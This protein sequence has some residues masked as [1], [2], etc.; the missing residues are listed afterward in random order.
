MATES[1]LTPPSTENEAR[2]ERQAREGLDLALRRLSEHGAVG[3]LALEARFLAE[4]EGRH[5]HA[6]W[7]RATETLVDLTRQSL[8]G[9]LLPCDMVL[10][11][12]VRMDELLVLFFRPRTS[13]RFFVD[14]LPTLP[15]A[16]SRFLLAHRSRIGHGP[17]GTLSS[18]PVGHA[19]VL[20]N[21]SAQLRR[22]FEIGVSR[23]RADGEL[24]QRLTE[25]SRRHELTRMI[26]GRDM[27]IVY[28]PILELG[29]RRVLGYE[30][31]LRVPADGVWLSPDDVFRTAEREGMIFELDVACRMAGL[32]GVRNRLRHDERLFLNTVPSAIHDPRFQ[33][34]Q[35][36]HLLASC[37]LEPRQI[38]VEL[39]ERSCQQNLRAVREARERLRA[40]G[41]SVALDD[42][43]NSP[44]SIST[45]M[46][47][48]PEFVKIDIALVRSS[49]TDEARQ[50]LVRAVQ[51]TVEAIGAT[52]IAEGIETEAELEALRR[53]GVQWGQGFLL[54]RP[55]RIPAGQG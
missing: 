48:D 52:S 49:D 50:R 36:G 35:F 2:R 26:L 53:L 40:L 1:V 20:H 9:H 18:L 30:A 17:G 8:E 13:L 5:G 51:D 4:I 32:R 41:I 7:R 45:L 25:K 29:E 55:A 10:A 28:Q 27:E 54:G 19:L 31:L 21:P 33:R 37:G 16:L 44:A 24:F 47:L 14:V 42:I 39:S 23:A 6:A 11:G 15:N 12:D 22:E 3:I 46:D 34:D 38:V 43:G